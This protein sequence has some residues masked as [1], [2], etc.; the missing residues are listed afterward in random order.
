MS[1]DEA[2]MFIASIDLFDKIW[3]WHMLKLDSDVHGNHWY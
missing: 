2:E 1:W 3:V